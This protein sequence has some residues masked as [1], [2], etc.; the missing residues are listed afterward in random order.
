MGDRDSESQRYMDS[1]K[2]RGTWR[3]NDSAIVSETKAC[4]EVMEHVL[5]FVAQLF[6]M[7][8]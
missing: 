7:D 5:D 2:A 3:D 6:Y 1:G 8:V 4:V